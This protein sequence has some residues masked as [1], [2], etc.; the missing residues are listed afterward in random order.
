V[1]VKWRQREGAITENN[2]IGLVNAEGWMAGL[3]RMPDWTGSI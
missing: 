2:N 1:K 3:L